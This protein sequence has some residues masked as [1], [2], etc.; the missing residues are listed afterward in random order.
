LKVNISSRGWKINAEKMTRKYR[1]EAGLDPVALIQLL[2]DKIYAHNSRAIEKDD[3]ALFSKVVR[4]ENNQIEA[5]IAGWTWAGV[6]EITQLWVDERLRGKGIGRLLLQEAEEE[7]KNKMCHTILVKSY[8]FQA[9]G[10]YE[11]HQYRVEYIVKGF[12]TGHEYY[13]LVKNIN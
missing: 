6:C 7:A 2:E 10:F 3:G 5:G 4:G 11:S 1:A 12:P 9:P 8:S 13:L